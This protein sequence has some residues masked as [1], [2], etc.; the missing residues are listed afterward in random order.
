MVQ[1]PRLVGCQI[2]HEALAVARYKLQPARLEVSA[3]KLSPL[4]S[5]ML[6]LPFC[7]TLDS[8]D[9]TPVDT[10]GITTQKFTLKASF[11]PALHIQ[12]TALFQNTLAAKLLT[13]P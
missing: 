9:I 13:N 3:S 1:R 8:V 7:Y 5:L 6:E 2:C 4:T 12:Y 10:A 11:S